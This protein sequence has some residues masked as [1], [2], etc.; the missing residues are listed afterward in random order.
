MRFWNNLH[1]AYSRSKHV[2]PY[3]LKVF[4]GNTTKWTKQDSHNRLWSPT[5][6]NENL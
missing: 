3:N 1:Q 5:H 6:G 2:K 4:G